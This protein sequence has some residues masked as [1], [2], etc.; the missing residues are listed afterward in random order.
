MTYLYGLDHSN[1]DFTKSKSFGKNTFTNAWPLAVA[2]YLSGVRELDIP[3]VAAEKNLK[4]KSPKTRIEYRAWEDIIGTS[5]DNARFVFETAFT[6]YMAYTNLP[7]IN[8]SDVVVFD[9]STGEPLHPLELKLIVVP[10]SGS[11][12]R[13]REKQT[14]ELVSRPPSIEQI[15]YS[16]AYGFTQ[17]RRFELQTIISDALGA[18]NDFNWRDIR[19]MVKAL[20]KFVAALDDII[21]AG[22]DVQRPLIMTSIWRSQGQRPLLDDHAFDVFVF[23]EL[24]FM[25]LYTDSVRKTYLDEN[26]NIREDAPVTDMTRAA[27]TVVWLV[28]SLW[29]YSTQRILDFPRVVGDAG[30]GKQTDKAGA[31]TD[32]IRDIL[33]SPEF[34]NPRVRANEVDSILDPRAREFLLP[35]RR[36][37][38]SLSLRFTLEKLRSG[39]AWEA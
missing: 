2:Q 4:G 3:V 1:K 23:T 20:P 35:E 21:R 36:L 32:P 28:R 30:Y 10:N 15:A 6:P 17:T 7:E 12:R 19:S 29:D 24:A 26:G 13:P 38:A 18:P 37:D 8:P 16:I 27:R 33:D 31:F 11:A 14:G 9:N 5:H 39:E 25:T 22:V 34:L